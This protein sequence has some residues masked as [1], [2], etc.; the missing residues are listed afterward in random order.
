MSTTAAALS[1]AF[2]ADKATEDRFTE[3]FF[4]VEDLLR[5]IADT[6][7]PD[8]RRK[9]AKLREELIALQDDLPKLAPYLHPVA[10]E[11]VQSDLEEIDWSQPAIAAL[12]GVALALTVL[13]RH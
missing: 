11:A 8:I 2:P 13:H 12:T 3:L 6:D 1:P 10:L 5:R 4:A 7:D 9:R